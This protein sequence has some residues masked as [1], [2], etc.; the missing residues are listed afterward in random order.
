MLAAKVGLAP[1]LPAPVVLLV[2]YAVLSQ[3][4]IC[5]NLRVFGA[6]FFDPNLYLGYSYRFLHLWYCYFH[7]TDKR[8]HLHL[9]GIKSNGRLGIE[10][11]WQ[12]KTCLVPIMYKRNFLTQIEFV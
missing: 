6:S 2:I 12:N 4:R 9:F 10:T 3:T 11:L 7:I 1:V 8:P 5:R